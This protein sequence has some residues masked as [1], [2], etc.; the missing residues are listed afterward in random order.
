M[1]ASR[2]RGCRH[3]HVEDPVDGE[4]ERN[5]A[6]RVQEEREELA[7]LL[8]RGDAVLE[9]GLEAGK[10]VAVEKLAVEGEEELVWVA[11]ARG[12]VGV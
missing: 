6:G 4:G 12:S 11:Q 9:F 1:C 7:V 10:D 8:V 5:G 3:V 2:A